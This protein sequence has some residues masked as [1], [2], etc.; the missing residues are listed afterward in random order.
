M[1]HN[2]TAHLTPKPRLKFH[3]IDAS[4]RLTKN[5]RDS[6]KGSWLHA[7]VR[8]R[9]FAREYSLPVTMT[10]SLLI[11]II[12]ISALRASGQTSLADLL[13]GITTPGE[14]YGTL[15]SQ[16]KTD[17]LKKNNDNDKALNPGS[18]GGSSF[19][20]NPNSGGGSPSTPGGGN[21]PPVQPVFSASIISFEKEGFTFVC[22]TPKQKVQ[23]CSKRYVF[24]AKIGT[25]NGPGLV[26]YSWLSNL[27]SATQQ[28]NISA[29]AGQTNTELQKI[30]IL[31][32]T[33]PADFN[34]RLVI[35]SPSSVNSATITTSHNCSEL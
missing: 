2:N 26:S 12:G 30:I 5:F 33:E 16:D 34:L 6:L 3:G 4:R 10:I 35:D 8:G 27:Q 29:G 14:D 18:D 24:N 1:T 11:L 25:R 23:T 17:A 32:C 28:G 7:Y 19:T 20:V 22:T 21:E 15:L 9:R 31:K 13:A